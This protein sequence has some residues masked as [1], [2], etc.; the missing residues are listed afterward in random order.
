MYLKALLPGTMHQI[1][2]QLDDEEIKQF[3]GLTDA[4][5]QTQRDKYNG[6]LVMHNRTFVNFLLINKADNKVIGK[7]GYHT[8]MPEHSRAEIGYAMDSDAVKGKGY[9][10]EAMRPIIEYGFTQMNLNRIEALIGHHNEASQRLV[11]A[12]GFKQ[13]GIL[14]EHYCKNGIL[15]D[16]VSWSLL[17]REWVQ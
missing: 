12:L 9:M 13:E 6:G 7:C 15:E 16:S 3:L 14:R 11:K 10:K 2:D 5:L 17:K 8:W 1:F 4:Q